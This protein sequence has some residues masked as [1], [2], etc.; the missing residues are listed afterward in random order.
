MDEPEPRISALAVV[1][2]AILGFAATWVLFIVSIL[3][4]Y[5]EA[6]TGPLEYV[7]P[8]VGLFGLPVL[9]GAL[10]VPRRTRQWGAGFLLGVAIGAITGAGICAGT[11]GVNLM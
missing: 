2:G 3:V 5:A 4:L 6:V 7:V 9:F 1:G 8:A 11:I 10:L